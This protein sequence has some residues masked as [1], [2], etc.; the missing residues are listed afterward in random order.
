MAR[1]LYLG[2]IHGRTNDLGRITMSC[3][4][5]LEK[6]GEQSAII[7]VGDF[8]FGFSDRAMTKWL[9][10]RARRTYKTPI[11]TCMGNHDNWDLLYEMW[12]EQGQPDLVEL[13]PDSN[14]FYVHR[15]SLVEIQGISHLFLGGAESIDKFSRIEGR[16]WW[17]TEQ[18]DKSEFDR[19]F[20]LFDN[21]KPN[22]VVTHEA[23]LRVELY[24]MR[25]NQSITAGGLEAVYKMSKH[26]PRRHYFGHHHKFQQWEIEGTKFYCC[27]LHGQFFE[28]STDYALG[29]YL[30]GGLVER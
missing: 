14:C 5:R 2:D 18:P 28:R 15:G 29:E 7:Q 23:P 20:D 21:E 16:D 8:G 25:R 1:L 22:T 27:G 17:A 10:K 6:H 11:Y 4:M 12:K 30:S 26:R 19:F 13:V 9:E 3:D 24:R